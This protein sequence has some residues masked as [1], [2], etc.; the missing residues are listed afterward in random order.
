MTP[1]GAQRAGSRLAR[2]WKEHGSLHV[3]SLTPHCPPPRLACNPTPPAFGAQLFCCCSPQHQHH[4]QQPSPTD[5]S[6]QLIS[7]CD[8]P[9]KAAPLPVLLHPRRFVVLRNQCPLTRYCTVYWYST[10]V[11]YGWLYHKEP[12]GRLFPRL[13]LVT[14]HLPKRCRAGIVTRDRWAWVGT[15]PSCLG[16]LACPVE[17]SGQTSRALRPI[18]PVFAALPMRNHAARQEAAAVPATDPV[19]PA[20]PM[21][22]GAA[23]HSQ[24]LILVA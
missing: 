20:P 21:D 7:S 24:G 11:Q 6:L 4:H 14:R 9:G 22:A 16:R 19:A 1:S 18:L 8:L 15:D 10:V 12:P 23:Q 2:G 5:P 3:L 17:M 13:A